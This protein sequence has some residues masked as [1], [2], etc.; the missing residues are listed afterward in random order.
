MRF[1]AWDVRSLSGTG[2][3]MTVVKELSEYVRC[4]LSTRGQMTD[5]AL[6]QQKNMHCSMKIGI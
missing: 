1:G 4:S 6:N 2:S 3:L 5:V